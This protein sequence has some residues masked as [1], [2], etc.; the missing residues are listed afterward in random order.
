MK[1][2]LVQIFEGIIDK[3][4]D[5]VKQGL[6]ESCNIDSENRQLYACCSF[7]AYVK[8][9]EIRELENVLCSKLNLHSANIAPLFV[10]ESFCVEAAEDIAAAIKAEKAIING[11]FNDAV[12]SLIQYDSAS[13]PSTVGSVGLSISSITSAGETMFPLYIQIA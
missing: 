2:Q 7:K 5:V 10:P 8:A 9:E 6:L 13:F 12:F 4:S 1:P 3:L 11:Y